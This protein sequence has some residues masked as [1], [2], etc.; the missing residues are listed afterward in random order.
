MIRPDG[1]WGAGVVAAMISGREPPN[2]LFEAIARRNGPVAHYRMAGE[3]VYL[4]SDPELVTDVYLTHAHDVMKGRGLQAARPLLG[5]G[6][7]TSEG[8]FHLRQR[9]LAQPAFHRQRIAAYADQMVQET[10][11]HQES[12][13]DGQRIDMVEEMTSLTFAVVGRTLFGTDLTGDARIF[14]EVMSELLEGFGQ[15]SGIGSERLVRALPQG[16]RL[17]SRVDDLDVVV[18]RII[19]EHRAKVADGTASDDLLTWM[20]QARDEESATTFGSTMTDDQLRDEVMTLVLAGHETTAMALSWAWWLLSSHPLVAEKVRAEATRVLAD[21][22]APDGLRPATFDDV[23]SL[24]YVHA[25]VAET[26]RLYPPAWV[27]GRRALTDM[28]VGSW[29]VPSGSI[30]LACPWILHRDPDLWPRAT[31]FNPDR[32]LTPD[33]RYDESAPGVP[34][35]AW[36]PFGF[37]NRRCIGE[38]FAWTEAVLVLAV[39]AARWRPRLVP[40]SPVDT[41]AAVT[42]RPRYGLPMTLERLEPR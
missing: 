13:H 10:L 23:A 1:P 32:W 28:R 7:L 11:R 12:W 22:T 40:G 42:L 31:S 35:G 9:R 3:H 38:Q 8:E 2:R 20:I 26:I 6:L 39:L 15:L 37:G 19:A 24:S 18:Q 33:G 36:I 14:G 30:F 34:R 21:P 5:N 41:L 16:R 4:L 29:D 27:M 25:V 17:L